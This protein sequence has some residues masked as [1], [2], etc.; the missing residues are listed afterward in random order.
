MKRF[1]KDRELL[2][3]ERDLRA[4]R[5]EAS[6]A[7]IVSLASRVARDRRTPAFTGSYAWSRLAFVA[8][9]TTA[10]IGAFAS[11]GG[12]GYAATGVTSTI[13]TLKQIAAADH[14][15]VRTKSAAADQYGPEEETTAPI[16]VAGGTIAGAQQGQL[17]FTGI[18]LGLTVAIALGFIAT[19]LLL[20]RREQARGESGAR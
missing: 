14:V 19:G 12:V 6:Q 13:S 3:L 17:P 2:Q 7:F 5:P 4:I 15:V 9:L 8:A 10:V 11:F 16:S 20:R 18:S 1:R